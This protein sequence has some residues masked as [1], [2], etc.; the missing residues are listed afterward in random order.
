MAMIVIV[1]GGFERRSSRIFRW[2]GMDVGAKFGGAGPAG[3]SEGVAWNMCCHV[4][5]G[6][7]CGACQSGVSGGGFRGVPTRGRGAY[8]GV[9]I[10]EAVAAVEVVGDENLV[11]QRPVCADRDKG[12]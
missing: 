3:S 7:K 12:R 1:S 11:F 5:A 4:A 8:G 6:V 10:P 2:E 9:D